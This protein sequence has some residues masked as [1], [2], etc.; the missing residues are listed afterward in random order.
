M[1]PVTAAVAVVAVAV[2]LVI[3]RDIS[4]GPVVPPAA[5]ASA[6]TAAPRYYVAIP[7]VAIPWP[8]NGSYSSAT[9]TSK[10]ALP[11]NALVVGDTATGKKLA[12]FAVACG[13]R[14][15]RR[16]R[17]RRRPD[18]RR[19]RRAPAGARVRPGSGTWSGSRPAPRRPP[20]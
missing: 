10:Q 20:R 1:A 14:V 3:V 19:L 12:T 5:S 6:L 18:V 7:G 11:P 2:S 13:H 9:P 15:D 16:D 17:R 8:S 4:N